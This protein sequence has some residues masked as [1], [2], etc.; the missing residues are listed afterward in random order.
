MRRI[1]NRLTGPGLRRM[2]FGLCVVILAAAG[3]VQPAVAQDAARLAGLSALALSDPEAALTEIATLLA[4]PDV[5]ANVRVAYDLNRLAAEVLEGQGSLDEAAA[6]YADLAGFAGRNRERLAADPVL[7]WRA[8]A[9]LAEAAGNLSAALRA[10]EA[11]LAEQRDGLMPAQV[12]ADTL[13]RMEALAKA[14][15]NEATASSYADARLVALAPPVPVSGARGDGRGYSAVEI[16]YATDRART[17]RSYPAEFYGAGRGPLETGI[18]VVTVPD[19]HTPGQLEAPSVWK[20]EFAAN[21]VR[22]VMLRSVEPVPQEAFFSRMRELIGKQERREAFIFIHGY[23]V[24][25]EAAARR[26]AQLAHDMNYSGLP[27]LYSWPSQGSTVGYISD[28]AVVQLSA[29]RLSRFLDQVVAQSEAEKI[30]IVAH[31]MGNRALTEALELMAL[32]HRGESE[33]PPFGQ[34]VFAAPDV[35]MGLFAEILPTISP[36]ASRMTLYASENDWALASSQ[37]LHGNAPRA[38][39][40]GNDILSAMGIDSVDMS[41][42]GEDMLAHGYFADDRSAL[43]DLVS[44]IWRNVDPEYRCGLQAEPAPSGRKTW[45]Y[46]P[47]QCPDDAL[48]AVIGTLQ[49][50]GIETPEAARSEVARIVTDPTLKSEVQPLVARMMA[51]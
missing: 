49:A 25:F 46:V 11:V 33:A 15:G 31:S 32:R 21:P 50:E 14:S 24:T 16:F 29:R 43:V 7:L 45:R 20:L 23:N 28:T 6:L 5:T 35:D 10:E 9:R 40:G 12:I 48:L 8:A 37:Q 30:H 34:I 41:E 47:G 36:L 42:L 1:A 2:V 19:E 38:G 26:A 13:A 51:P 17:G 3:G 18:A 44:L 22:H 4:R 39:Q 27:I